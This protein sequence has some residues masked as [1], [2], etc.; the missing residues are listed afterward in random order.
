MAA[1][2]QWRVSMSLISSLLLLS[3]AL[4]SWAACTVTPDSDFR[5]AK[6]PED[7]AP[8]TRSYSPDSKD[9]LPEADEDAEA[10]LLQKDA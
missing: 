9:A 5:I 8:R 6:A 7:L 1:A 10:P 2:Q 4:F 3:G